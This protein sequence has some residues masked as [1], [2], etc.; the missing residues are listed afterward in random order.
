[1][2]LNQYQMLAKT[3]A[4]LEDVL[5]KELI[6]LGAKEVE[7]V[8][9]G[10]RFSGPKEMLYKANFCC[11]TALRILCIV[12]EFKADNAT[13]LYNEMKKIDWTEFFDLGQTFAV[14]STVTSEAF[15]NSMFVSLKAKDAIVD[16]FRTKTGKRPSVN[17]ENP[18]I[19][20]HVH[21]AADTVSV[22]LDS[23]GESL[24]KRGYRIG[25]NEASMSEV[26][27]AG[28]LLL[29]N[30]RGQSDFYDPMC[31]SG[32]IAIEAALIARNI[33]PG[34]FRKAFAFEAWKDFDSE[35]FDNVYNAD[36]EKE[37]R[38]NIY[39]S[40]ISPA[41]IRLASENAR[42]AG[43]KKHIQFEASDFAALKPHG[44]IGF[45]MMNP[46]YGQR[47]ND[48]MV[49][50][51]Y[52]MIGDQ[53]KR[54]FIGFKAWIFSNSEEGFKRIGLRFAQRYELY[55][56]ALPCELRSF[57]VYEG[58]KKPSK[59]GYNSFSADRRGNQNAEYRNS[60]RP[61]RENSQDQTNR[62]QDESGSSRRVVVRK[63]D[64][65]R[66]EDQDTSSTD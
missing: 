28:L 46:P 31:G 66:Q 5:K 26:L 40:D 1:M 61:N 54:S 6:G 53:L 42:N 64:P 41:N 39:A 25:Q 9:R 36:Y 63:K 49:E 43:L 55:N 3:F 2:S 35:V 37:F 60:Y 4:G 50:P 33:P 38:Y 56:G 22:S 11:R 57:E 51:L 48:R 21:V 62:N 32:T 30:W 14:Y 20:I 24:H 13:D 23:S 18:D 7:Q 52:T 17:A 19:R 16:Q 27:A 34:M 10:V 44:S 65:D 15:N 59:Q 58:S 45:I 29:A 8:I 47:I 12:D